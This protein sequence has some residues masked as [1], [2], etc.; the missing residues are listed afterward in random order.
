MKGGNCLIPKYP[1]YSYE[2][3]ASKYQVLH[4]FIFRAKIIKNG[5]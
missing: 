4:F 3:N 5:N 1:Y 2:E